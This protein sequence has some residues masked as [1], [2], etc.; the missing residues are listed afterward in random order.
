MLDTIY[1]WLNNSHSCGFFEA[2]F[3]AYIDEANRW[4][5]TPGLRMITCICSA[6]LEA[7]QQVALTIKL[8]CVFPLNFQGGTFIRIY[9]LLGFRALVFLIFL[10]F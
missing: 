4:N 7:A 10:R 1:S 9:G 8:S 6:Q 2:T 5:W 3:V